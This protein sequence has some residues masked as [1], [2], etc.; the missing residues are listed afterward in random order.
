[1]RGPGG[2]VASRLGNDGAA[3]QPAAMKVAV[4]GASGFIGSAVARR[5][6]AGGHEVV[7]L[8]RRP[9]ERAD[10]VA[11]HPSSCEVEQWE[12]L[13]GVAAV[14]NLGGANLAAGRWTPERKEEI[15]RSRVECTRT[16]VAVM[17]HMNHHPRAFV[18]A[19]AVGYYGDRGEEELTE[20]S[21]RGQGFLADLCHAW[22]E[23]ARIAESVG[24]RPVMLR[25]GLVLGPGGG[26]LTRMLPAFR[27]GVGGHLGDGRQWMSWI[28]LE[29]LT[30]AVVWVLDQPQLSGPVNAVAPAGVRN[31]EFAAKLGHVL[32]RPAVM[33]VPA[34]MLRALFGEMADEALLASTRVRPARL[35]EAGFHFR[36]T[37]LEGV[38]RRAVE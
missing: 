2:R 32:G 28:G 25:M 20:A 22:E 19:S 7:R 34:V 10:E 36:Q 8:V 38:L 31:A 15:Q 11:W 30:E 21:G 14:V 27:C 37:D 24:I 13:E 16:L 12:R 6:A 17:A 4:A 33:A 3:C 26:V 29:D 18:C 35:H 23:E 1:M 9:A 5:L